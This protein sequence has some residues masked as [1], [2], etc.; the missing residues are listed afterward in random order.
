MSGLC[1]AAKLRAAGIEDFTIHEKAA[2]VGGTW[3]ENTYPGLSCDVPARYYSYSFAPNPSW[4]R[5]FAPGPEIQRYF[6][7]A[8]DQFGVRENIRF[9]SEVVGARWVDGRWRLRSADGRE[10]VADVVVT[11]T[12]VLHHPKVPAIE[13]LESFAGAAFHS[14]RWDHSVPLEGARIAVIGTGSTGVQITTALSQ[15][16]GRLDVMQRTPQWIIAFPNSRYTRLSRALLERFPA[17]ARASYRANQKGAEALFGQAVVKP[18]WQ[19][20]VISWACR[21][22]LRYGVKD[23][24]LRRRLTPPD[25]P[26]CRRL[27]LSAGYYPALQ[28][29]NVE[30]VTDGIARVEPGGIRT[31]AGE[32]RELDVIVLAT[33]F[34]AHAYVRPMEVVGEGGL[35]IDDAWAAGPR[36]Y[37]T[38]AVPDF[39]NYF[40][41]MGPHSPIGNHS[42]V[43][44][45]ETQAD[46]VVGW[47]ER[48]RAGEA[49]SVAPTREATARFN[50]DMRDAMPNTIWTSG[51]NSWYLGADGLPELFP[52]P[53][54]TY[55][56][57]LAE[58]VESDF[59]VR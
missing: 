54:E 29:D 43:A 34:D 20:S 37:R 38:V 21:M 9:G 13:G 6:V 5:F 28:C 10:D 15:V 14:A 42:L 26:M 45:A 57:M 22:N 56:E 41:L 39:P 3:R 46:F 53:P 36:A 58:P 48:L 49:D 4:S 2:E 31:T 30:L 25:K 17:L 47:I 32:L 8:A 40:M 27:I 44:T 11:A 19:R 18:G 51:C 16:A 55:R 1:M 59:V 23:P 33:G 35:T 12:G 7:R 50:D 24:E 52:W